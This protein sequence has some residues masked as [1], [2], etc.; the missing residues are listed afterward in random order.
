M[1]GLINVD[2]L[3][4]DVVMTGHLNWSII[5]GIVV[6]ARLFT[7]QGKEAKK[8]LWLLA[9]M[10]ITKATMYPTYAGAADYV[11]FEAFIRQSD[12]EVMKIF[13]STP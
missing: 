10:N 11:K 7:L 6:F 3:S 12:D 1:R 4:R 5:M 13:N 8:L 2:P 9:K